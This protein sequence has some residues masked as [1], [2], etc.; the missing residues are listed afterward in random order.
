MCVILLP[1][2]SN[3]SATVAVPVCSWRRS[4]A[5]GH[6]PGAGGTGP[7]AGGM[8]GW[9]LASDTATP[10]ILMGNRLIFQTFES[11]E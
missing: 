4:F 8:S 1:L 2:H 10:L 11:K 3:G 5:L 9:F 6:I 7:A